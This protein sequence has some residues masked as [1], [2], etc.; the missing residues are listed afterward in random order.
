MALTYALTPK[1]GVLSEFTV[2]RAA[3]DRFLLLGAASA[4]DHDLDALAPPAGVALVNRTEAM[5]SLVLAG[6]RARDVLGKVMAADVVKLDS[7]KTV[8]GQ[9][10]R[11]VARDGTVMIN[12]A[13]V[14]HWSDEIGQLKPGFYADVI[15]VPGDPI[16]DISVLKS[17]SFVMKNGE[18]LVKK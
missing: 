10:V 13:K 2:F 12:G 9:P 4:E 17:P 7:A 18:V 15:A 8:Q 3:E 6:P 1:G 5:G 14:L 11:I 16:K